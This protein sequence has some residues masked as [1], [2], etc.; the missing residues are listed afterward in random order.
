V[1]RLREGKQRVLY[2]DNCSSHNSNVSVGNCLRQIRT[3]LQKLPPNATHLVQPA[4][5]FIIQK[6]KEEWRARWDAYKYDAIRNGDWQQTADGKGSGKLRNPKK[7]FFTTAHSRCSLSCQCSKEFKRCVV[8]VKSD[9][10]DGDVSELK[11]VVGGS[12]S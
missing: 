4:D 3:T 8:R 9:G 12:L 7:S 1:G 11:R 2:V 5:S 10:D 6:I